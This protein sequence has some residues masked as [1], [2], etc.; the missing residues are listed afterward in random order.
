MLPSWPQRNCAASASRTYRRGSKQGVRPFGAGRPF[1]LLDKRRLMFM[2]VSVQSLDQAASMRKSHICLGRQGKKHVSSSVM[3]NCRWALLCV[4]SEFT[5]ETICQTPTPN[6]QKP[7]ARSK[8]HIV[9]HRPIMIWAW[10]L[11]PT[12][13]HATPATGAAAETTST[14]TYSKD[15]WRL[16][17][18]SHLCSG[19]A[20]CSVTLV[21]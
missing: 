11:L 9:Q 5:P 17:L 16:H 10:A 3:T 4:E 1:I 20:H 14:A 8:T 15:Q 21:M 12:A 18:G 7:K 2:T 6:T 19:Q 13:P